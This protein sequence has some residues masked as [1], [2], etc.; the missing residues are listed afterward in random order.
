M[1][2]KEVKHHV[3]SIRIP[4]PRKR[5]IFAIALP[6]FLRSA[7]RGCCRKIPRMT[8]ESSFTT[9][10]V[11]AASLVSSRGFTLSNK[12]WSFNGSLP[13]ILP[14]RPGPLTT[15][16]HLC[17]VAYLF[18]HNQPNHKKVTLMRANLQYG[19]GL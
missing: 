5:T 6:C 17:S 9:L 3:T 11:C 16:P 4:H 19:Q 2:A 8:S 12:R 1:E 13:E 14:L 10:A 15:T 18:T 7:L